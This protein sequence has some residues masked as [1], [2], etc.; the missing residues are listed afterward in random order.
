VVEA[1]RPGDRASRVFDVFIVGLIALNVAAVVLESV[2]KLEAR[3]RGAFFAFELASVAVFTLEYLARVWSA[4]TDPRYQGAF[5]GR[6]RFVLSPLALIDLLAV[7]PFY[8]GA[9]WVVDLRFLRVVRL[10][11]MIRIAK[12]ARYSSALRLLGRVVRNRKPELVITTGLMLIL[13]V[14]AS[15]MMYDLE[16]EVQPEVFGDIPSTMWWAVATMTTVG[17]GDTYPVTPAGKVLGGLVAILG[18]AFF[19][20]PA[21]ILGSGFVDEVQKGREPLRCPHC[22][23][24]IE[25]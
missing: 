15:C 17:Y 5:R 4:P 21:G 20:L 11:R 3:Y 8:L 14:L 9:L 6:L 18:I 22:G 12:V 2:A 1:A 7:F 24:E 10:V 19:A 13:L 23:V 16:H 25:L